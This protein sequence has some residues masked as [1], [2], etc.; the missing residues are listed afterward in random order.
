MYACLRLVALAT[1]VVVSPNAWGQ[2]PPPEA[3]P[4]QIAPSDETSSVTEVR[5]FSLR[6][7][8]AADMQ[9]TMRDL[10]G[11]DGTLVVSAQ[12]QTNQLV[13]VGTAS[14]IENIAALLTILDGTSAVPV[15][16]M[17]SNESRAAIS[18]ELAQTVAKAAQVELAFD[19]DLGVMIVRS[20]SKDRVSQFT[21]DLERLNAQIQEQSKAVDREVLVRVT[22]LLPKKNV[23]E[24][25]TT[26]P[27]SGLAETVEKLSSMGYANLAVAGQLMTRCSISSSSRNHTPEFEAEGHTPEGFNL[28]I[29]GHFLSRSSRGD[30]SIDVGM[31]VK[32]EQEASE[33]SKNECLLSVVLKMKEGKPIVLGSAPVAGAQSFFVVQFMAAD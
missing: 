13:V 26:A 25:R 28:A 7:V 23:E 30:D 3:I 31:T 19:E 12:P 4:P 32:V 1:F 9:K 6:N 10:Y 2:Q 18:K 33:E 22:W 29:R 8:A 17:L 5:V 20:D 16:Q 15:V 27:D 21:E 11:D 24:T 14:E